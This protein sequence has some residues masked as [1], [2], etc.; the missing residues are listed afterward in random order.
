MSN[1]SAIAKRIAIVT[2]TTAALGM[3]FGSGLA[4]AMP[5]HHHNHDT[6]SDIRQGQRSIFEG[7]TDIRHGQFVDGQAD[8]RAGQVTVLEG[9]GDFFH[10]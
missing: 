2:A 6:V 9:L 5:V 8:I 10:R 3:S 1:T 7:M 4:S